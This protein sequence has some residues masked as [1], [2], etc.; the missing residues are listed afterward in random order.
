MVRQSDQV[1]VGNIPRSMS[2]YA[3]GEN[4]RLAQPGDHV[5]ITGIFL[6]LLRTGFKQA[7]Q[8][9]CC[10]FCFVFLPTESPTLSLDLSKSFIRYANKHLDCPVLVIS[11]SSVRNL[12]GGSQ[13]HAHEQDGGWWAG[14]RW[15]EWR[16]A[17]WHHRS[18]SEQ[19]ETKSH[20]VKTN[21]L[22]WL[23]LFCTQELKR[24]FYV[25][26]TKAFMRSSPAQ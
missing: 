23:V 18:V 2:V 19:T 13:H 16:R 22:R 9:I 12:H 14:Q 25:L 15:A 3:R 26:Q 24:P 21:W 20:G 6:P 11:G 7:V 8:V 4:T 5:A 10:F 17:A 1:P